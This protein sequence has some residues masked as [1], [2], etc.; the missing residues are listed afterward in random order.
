MMN[1]TII[2]V[3]V[4]MMGYDNAVAM[5][6]EELVNIIKETPKKDLHIIQ[7]GWNAKIGTDA[8]KHWGGT[9]GLFGLGETLTLTLANMLFPHKTSRRTWH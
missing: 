4:P 3:Y 6:Y 9:I 7:Q 2:Q 5:F 1:I 8:Y